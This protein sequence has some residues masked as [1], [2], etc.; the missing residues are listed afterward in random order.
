MVWP[1]GRL[2]LRRAFSLEIAKKKR[3]QKTGA[4]GSYQIVCRDKTCSG[5]VP[6]KWLTLSY[7]T[8][9]AAR[10]TLQRD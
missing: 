4:L 10:N 9:G 2:E 7:E 5:F 6:L 3:P 8:R 1:D